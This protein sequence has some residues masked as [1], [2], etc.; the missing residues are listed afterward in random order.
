MMKKIGPGARSRIVIAGCL[1]LVVGAFLVAVLQS[2]RFEELKLSVAR[3]EQAQQQKI[4]QNKRAIAAISVLSAPQRIDALA[5]QDK[6][7][8]R[9]FPPGMIYIK[10]SRTSAPPSGKKATST[11]AV[12]TQPDGGQPAGGAR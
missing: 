10:T 12:D 1:V 4:E 7:L 11:E 9:G 8:T 2:F 5:A 6:S 3:L